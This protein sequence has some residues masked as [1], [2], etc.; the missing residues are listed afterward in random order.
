MTVVE[1]TMG[2]VALIGLL[3]T[4][5]LAPRGASAVPSDKAYG[6]SGGSTVYCS[7]PDR[8]AP[9][10]SRCQTCTQVMASI[11]RRC[12]DFVAPT[13]YCA[14]DFRSGDPTYICEY[15]TK[16]CPTN[17]YYYSDNDC[18]THYSGPHQCSAVFDEW[19]GVIRPTMGVN[20][21]L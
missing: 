17:A 11:W 21:D 2:A 1:R 14:D 5:W 16:S 19:S 18:G 12:D 8:Y 13:F 10:A 4:L 20:C 7:L 3:A 6:I 15:D 9:N